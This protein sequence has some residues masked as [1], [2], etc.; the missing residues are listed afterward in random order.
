MASAQY[1]FNVSFTDAVG[2]VRPMV[3]TLWHDTGALQIYCKATNAMFLSRNVPSEKISIEQLYPGATVVICAR[4]YKVVGCADA[5]TSR[6]LAARGSALVLVLPEAYKASGA[7]LQLLRA[8]GLG[9]GRMRMVRF[10][11]A[12]AEA[13]LAAG[14]AAGAPAPPPGAA[15]ALARDHAL[16]IECVGEDCCA[17]VHAA[18][19]PADAA[20]AR[21]ADP[22]CLRAVLGGD[23]SA[24]VRTSAS[25]AAAAAEVAFV[26]DRAYPFT[27]VCTHC[28]ALVVKPHAVA[29]GAEGAVLAA[30][31][32]AGLE[33]SALRS[34]ALSRSD[35]ADLFEPYK[36]VCAEYERWAA[37]CS[38]GVSV[39]MEVRGEGV[40]E[41][42]RE[43]AG[44]NDVAVARL[45]APHSLRA[46][47][48]VDN[49]KNAVHV[50][51][52]AVD[53]PLECRF[54]FSVAVSQ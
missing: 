21:A 18:V 12:E 11:Q 13:F 14:A 19:G 25:A 29:A 7:V 15:A 22:R 51:D 2:S 6:V 48:G 49:V 26:F 35:A 42:L 46:R 34:C 10:S 36:G 8:A 3:L 44:P 30:V 33:V 4:P 32:G 38:S 40:V 17:R 47:F 39:L 50:T 5:F 20:A 24:V 43:L 27:A 28:A 23:G 45:L 16:A 54:L 9:L 52:V 41:A 37:E 31:L 53:G 1:S